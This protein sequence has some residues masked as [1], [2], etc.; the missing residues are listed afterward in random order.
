M[1]LS[2][3]CQFLS[4]EIK[5]LI[6]S[7]TT[8]FALLLVKQDLENRHRSHS[9]FWTMHLILKRDRN[10]HLK[11]NL[12]TGSQ[13]EHQGWNLVKTK[14]S[15]PW[16]LEWL[17]L[18]QE[19]WRPFKWQKGLPKNATAVLAS[20]LATQFDLMMPLIIESLRLS[21]SQTVYLFVSVCLTRT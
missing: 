5:S 18:N 15:I 17:S 4:F 6:W 7:E 19:E 11:S 8:Y 13:R 1:R 21:T 12:K 20:K 2:E 14:L 16:N 9:T 10:N 3:I